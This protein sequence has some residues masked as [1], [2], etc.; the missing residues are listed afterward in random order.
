MSP[1]ARAL[2]QAVE[3]L[4]FEGIL[5]PVAGGWIIGRQR[6]LAPY[7]MQE[8]GRIRLLAAPQTGQGTALTIGGLGQAL[9]SAGHDPARL[10][11]AMRRSA[12]F[13]RQA[14]AAPPARHL[15]RGLALE[16]T[17]IEGH[18]YHP[19]FKSR[20]GF[21]AADNAAFGP[22]V[23]ARFRP[24]WLRIAPDLVERQ[25]SD[26]AEGFAPDGAIP[27]HP[28]QWRLLS[29]NPALRAM[30]AQIEVLGHDGPAMVATASLRTLA[31]IDGSD[32]LKLSLAIGVT[33]S[34]RNLVPW[35]V[36]VAPAI[37]AWLGSVVRD[38]PQLE[39]L[40]ILPEHG[41]AIVL[42]DRLQG[43]LA[44]I[45]RSPPPAD[46]IPVSALSLIE[47]D[48]SLLIAPW[49]RRHGTEAW[50]RAYL[51]CLRPIWHLMGHHGIAIEAHGQ[52]LL[53]RLVDGW[54]CGLV[55]RDFS[56]SLEYVPDR[57]ARPDLRPDLAAIDAVF[58]D[59]PDGLYHRMGQATDLRDLVMDCLVTHVLSDLANAL[60][61]SGLMPEARFWAMV[62]EALPALPD[63]ATD[64]PVIPAESLAA[65]LLGRT[66]AHPAPNPLGKAMMTET[67]FRLN[68]RLI[69]PATLDLPDPL[70]GLDPA[71]ARVALHL[72]DSGDCL[73]LILRLRD[74]GSSVHPIHP[75]TPP[76]TAL[77]LARR[78][79]CNRIV[80]DQGVIALAQEPPETP[81]GALIQTSSGTTGAPK[82][83]ARRWTEI[84]TEIDAYVHAFPEAAAMTPVIAAPITHSY[85]LI[86]GVMVGQ[87]RGHLPLV[88]T[89]ANPRRILRHLAE[90]PQ[91]LIYAAPPLLQVLARL[92]GTDGIH[93][94]M[95]SGTVLPRPWFDLLG[96]SCRH[97][98][99]QYGCSEAGCVSIA[100]HP[101]SP[102]DMGRPLPHL[103][104][105]AGRGAAGP[106]HV[107]TGCRSVETGDLGMMDGQGNLIFAGRV[108]EVID[109]AGINVHPA[110]LEAAALSLSGVDDA[111]AFAI[112]DP[113]SHQRP[114]LAYAGTPLPEALRAHLAQRL[115]PQQRPV[116]L[117]HL[118]V[119]PRGTNGK[120]ARRELAQGLLEPAR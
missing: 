95:S 109:V 102:E 31:P 54:P 11:R 88:L 73:A 65:R 6:I 84:A 85:G 20:L 17:L 74:A 4:A 71:H 66:E 120:I 38:D 90:T 59:A 26:V 9:S 5:R 77:D 53:V 51:G 78:S 10:L 41:A 92:A 108:A 61:L 83:I 52:N 115:S 68:D 104:V 113:V 72:G 112:A 35:C 50:L 105:T 7:R 40:S 81:G 23:G 60:H 18:P 62:R 111:V 80:T 37:S 1:E 46:A 34:R 21:T 103:R 101:A 19:G 3:S 36:A 98:F 42:R 24:V 117:F 15:L 32:H 70:I 118:P 96:R 75:D 110:D 57:L 47:S 49:L 86:A 12:M 33:S 107:E 69:D 67:R 44:V 39:G 55:A 27:V 8:S 94:A 48:G 114:A 43:Q 13:L 63:L 14:G 97:L 25:G 45:R 87:R 119:L 93:A 89:G 2:R 29:R 91:P 64:A 30:G 58:A 22:E 99:Q 100:A 16:A 106:V 28:W 56:E 76:A 79:G 116:R 82:I